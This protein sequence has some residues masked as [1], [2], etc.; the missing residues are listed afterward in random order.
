MRDNQ[1][2]SPKQ[3]GHA[4]GVSEASIKRWVDKGKIDCVKTTGGHRKIP[5]YSLVEYIHKHNKQLV[6]PEA[7]NIPKSTGRVKDKMKQSALALRNSFQECDEFKIRGIIYD[8][9]LSGKTP[10]EIFDDLMAPALHQL[11][12]DWEAGTVDCFQERRTI[13]ICIRTLYG[14]DSFF[15]QPEDDA[16]LAIL[17]TL[18]ND[19]YTIP[20]I[21]TEVCLRTLGWRTG[22]L[23]NDIPH[24]SYCKAIEMY[25]PQLAI[26]SMS[27]IYDEIQLV[28]N[29]LDI[30]ETAVKQNCMLV[31][32]G[33]SVPELAPQKL[34]K[35]LF[36]YSMAN[37]LEQTSELHKFSEMLKKKA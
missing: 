31:L 2:F 4:L 33:R 3:V 27:A 7:L 9:Y 19:P 1:L 12:C 35:S 23:G 30:E 6:N 28:E 11:G 34:K 24:D 13:Q 22:F 20:V 17:G 29:L 8:L 37:F 5:L 36:V 18:S 14:F 16:P 26:V 32:G 25:K 10:Q 15:P 21:M